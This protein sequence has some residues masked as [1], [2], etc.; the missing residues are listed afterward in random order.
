MSKN[1][2]SFIRYKALDRCFR[3]NIHRY[4]IEDLISECEKEFKSS[5][6]AA[7]VSRRQIFDDIR[8][9]ESEEGWGIKLNRLKD[10]KRIYYR[11]EKGGSKSKN[12]LTE[13]ETMQLHNAINTLD[14]FRAMPGYEWVSDIIVNLECRLDLNGYS[15][16]IISFET[17]G[18]GVT[19]LP[20][21]L[22]AILKKKVLEMRI[23]YGYKRSTITMHPY[24]VKQSSGRLFVFGYYYGKNKSKAKVGV[25]DMDRITKLNHV[26]DV[27]FVPNTDIDYSH[28]F[29]DVLGV[30][31]P[32]REVKKEHI[33][34]QFDE[35]WFKTIYNTP[36]HHSQKIVNKKLCRISLD[37]RPTKK[38]I[39]QLLYYGSAVEVRSPESLK[40]M[41]ME[42]LVGIAAKYKKYSEFKTL[43]VMHMHS[44]RTHK[45]EAIHREKAY[46]QIN[47]FD[48][49]FNHGYRTY[50]NPISLFIK[51]S[52]SKIVCMRSYP[53][54]EIVGYVRD[55]F[56]LGDNV[57]KVCLDGDEQIIVR[58]P[59]VEKNCELV[60]K[61]L[62][63][64]GCRL[65]DEKSD[66]IID[67][68]EW[69]TLY[70]ELQ[71]TFEE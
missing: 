24:Y 20:A 62:R 16:E 57:R 68:T 28:R 23:E 3:D 11:Y 49:R 61:A 40:R 9:M 41:L 32:R 38:L 65:E 5:G 56:R 52:K 33:I 71:D 29:D 2:N 51:N 12:S 53:I 8:F 42:E 31:L 7:K 34:L 13:M 17:K 70:F 37:L 18:K 19:K 45:S 15:E 69:K 67:G 54:D 36:I 21:I 1:N 22:D 50:D 58:F 39:S 66:G 43:N 4:F 6:I 46:K 55:Y 60:E 59:N 25:F 35:S 10:G 27:E 64:C 48:F 30:R 47:E 14:R 63:I 26:D 44:V